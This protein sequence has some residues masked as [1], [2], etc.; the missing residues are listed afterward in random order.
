MLTTLLED[1]ARLPRMCP[2][3]DSRTRG[4]L[5]ML[6]CNRYDERSALT[7]LGLLT[8]QRVSF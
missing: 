2:G 7:P 6:S 5:I 3:F 4:L 8:Q 1:S